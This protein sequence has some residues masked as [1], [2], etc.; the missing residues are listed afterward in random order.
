M[1]FRLF[2]ESFE[3]D[4]KSFYTK[5]RAC[6]IKWNNN[7]WVSTGYMKVYNLMDHFY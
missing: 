5:T 3:I 7:A 1:G 4:Y 6:C 2:Y